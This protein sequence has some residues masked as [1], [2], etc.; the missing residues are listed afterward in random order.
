[1][2]TV[3]SEPEEATAA[4]P[5]RI[6]PSQRQS[7]ASKVKIS[8]KRIKLG[9]GTSMIWSTSDILYIV[10]QLPISASTQPRLLDECVE[11]LETL[12][13]KLSSEKANEV[14]ML[15]RVVCRG[16]NIPWSD[17]TKHP[18]FITR[19]RGLSSCLGGVPALDKALDLFHGTSETM[20]RIHRDNER[21][22]EQKKLTRTASEDVGGY[23]DWKVVMHLGTPEGVQDGQRAINILLSNEFS[24][25]T[26]WEL[27]STKMS[28]PDSGDVNG[29]DKMLMIHHLRKRKRGD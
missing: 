29:K 27:A 19:M 11:I 12:F 17:Q 21:N 8:A 18:G 24:N 15:R 20:S 9:D 25:D 4:A 10:G 3:K 23:F 26:R 7:D 16:D 14:D 22:E 1:M 5:Y 6:P 2:T 13:S 28:N